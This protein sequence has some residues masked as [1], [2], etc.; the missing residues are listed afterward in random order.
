MQAL[1][2]TSIAACAILRSYAAT[3]QLYYPEIGDSCVIKG[4]MLLQVFEG[5]I[6]SQVNCKSYVIIGS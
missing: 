6:F 4:Q 2:L 1:A 5:F 3:A